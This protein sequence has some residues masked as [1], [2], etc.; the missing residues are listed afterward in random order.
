MSDLSGLVSKIP[1]IPEWAKT[2]SL[3]LL[4]LYII[5]QLVHLILRTLQTPAMR[6]AIASLKELSGEALRRAERALELPVERPRLTLMASAWNAALLYV[7]SIIF[8]V[9]FGVT[10]ILSATSEDVAFPK[11]LA[12]FAIAGVF[13]LL[14]RWYYVSAEKQRIALV[15]SWR[16]FRVKQDS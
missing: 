6:A 10:V 5:L 12:G 7:Y 11:H 13:L 1:V 4:G 3:H 16:N 14:A 15:K 2:M 9:Y 8:F